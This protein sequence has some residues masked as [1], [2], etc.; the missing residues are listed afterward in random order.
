MDASP[1]TYV[2]LCDWPECIKEA[3]HFQDSHHLCRE[4]ACQF[5]TQQH[6]HETLYVLRLAMFRLDPT[7]YIPAP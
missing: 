6:E 4:H 3:T 2:D 5:Q 7:K 1:V